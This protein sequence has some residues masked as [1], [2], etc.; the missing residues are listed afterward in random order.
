MFA[1][2]RTNLELKLIWS[3]DL[4]SMFLATNRTN[5]ELKRL[6]EAVYCSKSDL[7]IVPIWN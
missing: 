4:R 7:P 5:L 2:N 1:T 3:F 6:K